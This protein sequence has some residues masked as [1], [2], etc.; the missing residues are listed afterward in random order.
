MVK[1]TLKP[2]S[3]T[4]ISMV[5]LSFLIEVGDRRDDPRGAEYLHGS[6]R[7]PDVHEQVVDPSADDGGEPLVDLEVAARDDPGD[8]QLLGGDLRPLSG[9]DLLESLLAGGVLDE[10]HGLVDVVED[11][12]LHDDP[13]SPV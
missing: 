8:S 4:A 5:R 1:G 10:D 2:R 3:S 13:R 12:R 11:E 7:R 9:D 6:W